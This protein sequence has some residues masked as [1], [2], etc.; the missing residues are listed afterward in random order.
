MV[1]HIIS[2]SLATLSSVYGPRGPTRFKIVS[3]ALGISINLVRNLR[4]TRISRNLKKY[5]LLYYP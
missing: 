5:K 1:L 4:I 2:D 3:M